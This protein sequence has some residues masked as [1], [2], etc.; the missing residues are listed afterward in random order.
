MQQMMDLGKDEKP[1][2]IYRIDE[3]AMA[4]AEKAT[5]VAIDTETDTE[6]N[7]IG[8]ESDYGLSYAADVLVISFAWDE[9]SGVLYASD[10]QWP[11]HVKNWLR[12]LYETKTII[13]H[14]AVFDVRQLSRLVPG[15]IPKLMWDTMT[16]ERLLYP[17]VDKR[18]SLAEVAKSHGIEVPEQQLDVKKQRGKLHQLELDVLLDYAKHDA[19]L[20]LAVYREQLAE[21]KPTQL[22]LVE[23][24]NAATRSYCRMAAQGVRIDAGRVKERIEE[25]GRVAADCEARLSAAG[26]SKPNSPVARREFIWTVKGLPKPNPKLRDHADLFTAKW[27]LSTGADALEKYVEVFPEAEEALADLITWIDVDRMIATLG[28]LLEH[29]AIDG[30]VHSLVSVGT[31]TGR[32]K[33]SNPNIQNLKM[34]LKNA[35]DPAGTMAGVLVGDEGATLVEID[36]SNAENWIAALLAADNAFASACSAAD[37]HSA[38]AESYFGQAWTDGDASERKRL[39]SKGKTITF[40]T[41]YGMGAMTLS[42]RLGCTPE[43]AADLLEAKDRA[44]PKVA[45]AKQAAADKAKSTGFVRLWTGRKVPCDAKRPYVAWNYACQGAVGELIKNAI[46]KIDEALVAAGHR[47]Y[48]AI[49]MHDALILNVF[50]SEWDR[51]IAIASSIME[52]VMPADLNHRTNPPVKWIAQPD[53]DENAHKWGL[54]Q[55]HPD[56]L[57]LPPSTVVHVSNGFDV[58]I[59]RN[60]GGLKDQ[61]WGNPYVIG[62]DGTRAQV[63]E[64]YRAYLLTRPDLIARLPSLRFKKLGCFCK[65]ASAPDTACHGDV[66]VELASLPDEKLKELATAASVARNKRRVVEWPEMGISFNVPPAFERWE[67]ADP[68]TREEARNALQQVIKM[69]EEALA[70]ESVMR[71]TTGALVK[72]DAVN[73]RKVVYAWLKQ[74]EEKGGVA[75]MF[76]ADFMNGMSLEE[77]REHFENLAAELKVRKK[78]IKACQ[79][80]IEALS[81]EEQSEV[82][83]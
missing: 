55:F 58:Y 42:R 48:V 8:P 70:E 14:N 59:G 40:G 50:H 56:P 69:D 20:T 57:P 6:W 25:L 82:A 76:R 10:G 61:G 28:N 21:M 30:R 33:S 65:T 34:R 41:A 18:F 60:T 81:D 22:T 64:K 53:L 9:G 4:E 11:D 79:K 39:R 35:H 49:D 43:E 31:E 51:V 23:V 32:R 2:P 52:S 80:W 7:G 16:N 26:L 68:A 54:G 45:A 46:W 12:K 17:A 75:N 44:F 62:R 15:T 77:V 78:R 37:F 24:E 66:L 47:S 29:A 19:E 38:M 74:L 73:Y 83:A 3:R 71:M 27:E 13:M 72:V 1:A 67:T 36:Y 63:I 5:R